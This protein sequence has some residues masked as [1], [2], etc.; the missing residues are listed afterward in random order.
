MEKAEAKIG[1]GATA[2]VLRNY[3][4]NRQIAIYRKAILELNM[5]TPQGLVLRQT[6][7]NVVYDDVLDILPP[8]DCFSVAYA[9][10]MA[11][12]VRANGKTELVEKTEIVKTGS[13]TKYLV[14]SKSAS[15]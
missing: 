8:D 15:L 3:L 12:V 10:D 9:D 5:G 1:D 2:E 7:W 11:V 4:R 14:T 13:C 6:L